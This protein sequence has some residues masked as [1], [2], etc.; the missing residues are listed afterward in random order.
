MVM[1]RII[2]VIIFFSCVLQLSAEEYQ[3]DKTRENEKNITFYAGINPLALFASL[4]RGIG[5]ISTGFGV[6]SNQEYGISLYGGMIY[7]NVHSLEMRFSTGPASLAMWDTQL[8]FGYI[9]Y[10]FQQFLDWDGGL[11]AGLILRQFFWHNR[12]TDNNIYNLTPMAL[13]GWRFKVNSLAIDLRTGWNFASVTWSDIPHTKAGIGWTTF[14]FNL[15][16]SFGIAWMF[17]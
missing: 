17:N 6:I 11:T 1:K 8:Q 4:P 15:A 5:I 12:I 10:P 2:T 14:P 13:L 7:R 3:A 9:W 16:L